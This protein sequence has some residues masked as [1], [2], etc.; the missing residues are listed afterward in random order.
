MYVRMYVCMYECIIII[1]FATHRE[2]ITAVI[3]GLK[4]CM[5][6]GTRAQ[7]TTTE[8]RA[9]ANFFRPSHRAVVDAVQ[10]SH[11]LHFRRAKQCIK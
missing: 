3:I 4:S 2:R 10:C 11:T 5:P 8:R 6:A 9:L 7:C 1:R